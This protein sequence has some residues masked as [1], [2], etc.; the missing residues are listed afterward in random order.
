MTV[1]RSLLFNIWFF[2]TTTLVLIPGALVR[3][4]APGWA[5]A[6]ARLWARVELFGARW[7]CGIRVS[8]SGLEHLPGDGAALLASR[9][10][11]AFDTL[12]WLTLVPRVSYVFKTELLRIPVFGSLLCPA[13]MIPVDRDGGSQALRELMRAGARAVEE[14]RQIV[15]FPEG[16]R[17]AP[18]DLLPLQPGVAALAAATKL[19]VIPVV[20][21]SGSLWGRRAFHK[22]SG[23]IHI[24]LLPPLPV[25]LKSAELMTRLEDALR[26]GMTDLNARP[27]P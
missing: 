14:R 12:V 9:H 3:V 17:G 15:I 22:L 2:G 4:F 20:T 24:R 13:G 21:D 25:G 7:I 8:V 18:G 11:S 1:L 19:P 10:E 26:R 27:T 6:L 23:T 16:T 5:P